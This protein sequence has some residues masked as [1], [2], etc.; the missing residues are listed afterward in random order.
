MSPANL[1]NIE[2]GKTG[3]TQETLEALA[4]ALNCD[5]ADL[6]VRNPTDPDSIWSLWDRAKPAQRKQIVGIIE[7]LLRSSDAA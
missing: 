4:N 7:G 3:Y 5:V 1:S 6:L 2:T